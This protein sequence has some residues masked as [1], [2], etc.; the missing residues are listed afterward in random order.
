MTKLCTV[1]GCTREFRARGYCLPHYKRFKRH[2]SP[3]AGRAAPKGRSH[4]PLNVQLAEGLTQT[5]GGCIEWSGKVNPGGYGFIPGV[6]PGGR[7]LLAHR[8]A[9]E[10]ANG[11][12]IP[13]RMLV[14]HSCD[15]RACCNPEH[16]FLGTHADNSSDMVAKGRQARGERAA[17]AILTEEQVVEILLL[18][19][20]GWRHGELAQLFPVTARQVGKIC[21]GEAWRHVQVETQARVIA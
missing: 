11:R 15:N 16:L 21:R 14:C 7:P 10:I 17:A 1:D 4:I 18:R 9:W 19:A 13:Q 2:G 6:G 12:P 20:E 8:V 3:T 5:E